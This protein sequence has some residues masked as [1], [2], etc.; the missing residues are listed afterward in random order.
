MANKPRLV[1][2]SGQTEM[3]CPACSKTFTRHNAHIRGATSACSLECSRKIRPTKP[4]ILIDCKCKECDKPF[5]IRKGRG[6]TGTYC[7]I[8]CM[9]AARGRAMRKENHPKWNGG[10]SE[11]SFS[12]RQAITQTIKD[13]GSCEMCGSTEYLQ[14]HHIKS[15]SSEPTLRADPKNI[16]VLCRSC[17]ATKHPRLASFILSGKMIA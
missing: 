5:Q 11:R 10:S 17:H 12:S 9:A 15:H 7:S 14:G 16:Q 4:K 8:P 6:G 1:K 3:V 2:E 13:R